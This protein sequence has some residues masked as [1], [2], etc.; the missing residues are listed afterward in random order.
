[1]GEKRRALARLTARNAQ[2]KTGAEIA[3]EKAR[4]AAALTRGKAALAKGLER[5]EDAKNGVTDA[6]EGVTTL[7]GGDLEDLSNERATK[8]GALVKD[9]CEDTQTA[10]DDAKR[11]LKEA[12]TAFSQTE[13]QPAQAS[14]MIRIGHD[15]KQRIKQG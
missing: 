3:L 11:L 14:N 7:A 5:V 12:S 4:T 13:R 2:A 15:T 6:V 8:L 10:I 9:L 1:M